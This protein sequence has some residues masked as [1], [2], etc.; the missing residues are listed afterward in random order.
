MY[1]KKEYGNNHLI[2]LKE[3]L[4]TM[5][6]FNVNSLFYAPRCS[7]NGWSEEED[8]LL[9]S[10]VANTRKEG[11]PLR[12]AFDRVAQITGRRPNSIRNYYYSR[13]K[14]EL[15]AERCGCQ[16]AT[17]V[18]FSDEEITM[19]L[20]KVLLAQAKGQSVRAC[21]L[22]LGN[23]DTKAMLRYQNKYRSIL[24]TKPDLILSVISELEAEGEKPFNPYAEENMNRYAK[25]KSPSIDM[26]SLNELDL[27]GFME[28]LSTLISY[29]MRGA[30]AL[31]RL[32]DI[33][34]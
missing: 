27:S 17:F 22:E 13:I 19:L 28:G 1:I 18:P 2:K 3:V 31:R 14:D 24:K 8:S 4:S 20:K 16:A 10:E 12:L 32:H 7:K 23:G 34:A 21:T 25:S 6:K 29:A 11:R 26:Q 5:N 33:E 9:L 15:I 30:E